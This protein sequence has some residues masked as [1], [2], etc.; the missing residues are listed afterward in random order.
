[1]PAWDEFLTEQ[2]HRL[3]KTWG[4]TRSDGVGTRPALLIVDAYYEALG[5]E[6]EPIEESVKRWPM[7]CGLAGWEA[8]DRTVDL[9]TAARQHWIPVIYTRNIEDFPSPWLRWSD[10]RRTDLDHLPEHERRRRNQIVDE[11]APRPGELVIEKAAPSAFA[12]TPLLFHMTYLGVDTVIVCG[13]A[14]SGCVR[15]SVVDGSTA[16]LRMMIVEDCCFD[17]IE[18]SHNISLFDMHTKYG[19]VVDVRT[20]IEYIA[21]VGT[22]R[23]SDRPADRNQLLSQNRE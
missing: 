16:R 20:A 6:R 13:E 11:L 1:V 2:D 23:P 14:T 9:L 3:L 17:R 22:G 10:D 8:I 18:A 12:S 7:S 15:A 4:K 5:L 19:D 21:S